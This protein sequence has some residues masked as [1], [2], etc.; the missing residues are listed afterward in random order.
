MLIADMTPFRGQSMDVGTAFETGFAKARGL[1]V[2]SYSDVLGP[3]NGR[4]P[5]GRPD[6]DLPPRDAKGLLI[7]AFGLQDNL[8]VALCCDDGMTHPGLAAAP[9]RRGKTPRSLVESRPALLVVDPVAILGEVVERWATGE[10]FAGQGGGLGASG[11]IRSHP[12]HL[13]LPHG[14]AFLCPSVAQR[15]PYR[16]ETGLAGGLVPESSCLPSVSLTENFM[17]C[18]DIEAREAP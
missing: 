14:G 3:Y 12:V 13:A 16:R 10:L 2:F 11:F 6:G 15:S 8:M 17:H 9:R 1:A 5:V 7:E 18:K 4:V